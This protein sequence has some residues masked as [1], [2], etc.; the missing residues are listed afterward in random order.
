MSGNESNIGPGEGIEQVRDAMLYSLVSLSQRRERR[1]GDRLRRKQEY[2]RV[3]AGRLADGQVLNDEGIDLLCLAMPLHDIGMAW[4]ADSV[5][6]KPGRLTADELRQMRKHTSY[7][8]D[9]LS[10][11]ASDLGDSPFVR[12]AGEIAYT[13][14]EMWNGGG[15]PLGLRGDDIPLSGRLTALVDV[16]DALRSPRVYNEALSHESAVSLI[17][18]GR[19]SHFDPDI[20]DAFVSRADEF[21]AV[22]RAFADPEEETADL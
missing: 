15:Y 13:H 4:V 7:G 14:H 9:I 11:V 17:L 21:L 5:L 20:V 3:L 1:V 19:G 2:L 10:R 18:E 8:R 6:L 22:S 16:Y 12:L